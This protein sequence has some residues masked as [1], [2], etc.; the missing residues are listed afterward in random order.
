[1]F[2]S[3]SRIAVVAE[4]LAGMR[5]QA[6]GLADYINL[7]SRFCAV[8]ASGLLHRRLPSSLWPRPLLALSEKPVPARD[9][10][11]FSV[12][13]KGGAVGAALRHEG[14][15]VVQIQNPRIR[16][17]RFDLV[18]A[19]H[20]DEM[21]G[22]NV[23]L[24]RTALHGLTTAKLAAARAHWLDTLRV[25]DRPLLAALVG[26]ANGRFRF[27]R[28]E[29]E[30]L[31][32]RL[33]SAA[34]QTGAKLFITTSRRTGPE[35]TAVLRDAVESVHGTLW[36]DGEDNPYRGLIACADW[37]VVTADSVSMISEAVASSVPVYVQRLPGKSRRI[38]LFL[39]T[40]EDAGRIRMFE[41]DVENW[42]VTPLDDTPL[43]AHE[44]CERLGLSRLLQT[45]A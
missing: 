16:P 10:L 12:A 28:E 1:M 4:D 25:P 32:D 17:D 5:S 27:G 26:G 2:P 9:D 34:R 42:P 20:H 37:L 11:V 21:E 31:A 8:R 43:V 35:A 30:S 3:P 44:M 18:I 40:L 7:P 6:F 13:G 38:G 41:G 22:P 45:G 23:L 39:A 29:A 14:R 36:S 33:A 15:A 19:N 24:S